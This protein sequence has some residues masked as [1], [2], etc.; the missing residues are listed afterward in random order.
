MSD[1]E[2]LSCNELVRRL[3]F[4]FE[5]GKEDEVDEVL[6]WLLFTYSP[7]HSYQLVQDNAEALSDEQFVGIVLTKVKDIYEPEIFLETLNVISSIGPIRLPLLVAVSPLR[8]LFFCRVSTIMNS[9]FLFIFPDTLVGPASAQNLFVCLILSVSFVVARWCR[10]ANYFLS[11]GT[12][13]PLAI[14][15]AGKAIGLVMAKDIHNARA[16]IL[17]CKVISNLSCDVQVRNYLGVRRAPFYCPL[18]QGV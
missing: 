8:S 10:P 12:E 7:E 14:G 4:L 1:L 3:L 5:S 16:Q 9:T 6:D 15:G 11:E 13:H 18:R 17:A 2:G